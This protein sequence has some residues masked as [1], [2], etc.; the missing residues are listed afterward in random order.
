MRRTELFSYA[1]TRPVKA[2]RD[3]T[4]Q[5]YS[6]TEKQRAKADERNVLASAVQVEPASFM[7]TLLR[8]FSLPSVFFRCS[9]NIS[10]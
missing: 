1:L 3:Q 10:M 8:F 2:E 7:S 4:G 5:Q 9:L 6:A